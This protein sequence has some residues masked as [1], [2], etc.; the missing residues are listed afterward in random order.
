VPP[1]IG[2]GIL[3]IV[4]MRGVA[5]LGAIVTGVSEAVKLAQGTRVEI[6]TK[7]EFPAHVDGEPWLLR[8]CRITIEMLNQS[9]LLVHPERRSK[10]L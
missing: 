3:E 7:K 6:V 9:C 4:G 1:A 8:P 2:D 5:H 10:L